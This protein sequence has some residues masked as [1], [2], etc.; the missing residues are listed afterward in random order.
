M[1]RVMRSYY[2]V[3]SMS[4]SRYQDLHSVLGDPLTSDIHSSRI[5]VVGAGGIGCELLKNMVLSGFHNIEI[6]CAFFFF[7]FI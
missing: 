3:A 1:N 7:G 2:L 5:L 6:V 4:G